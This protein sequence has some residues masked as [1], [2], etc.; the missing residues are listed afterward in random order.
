M[1]KVDSFYKRLQFQSI[2]DALTEL[3]AEDKGKYF[4]CNCPECNTHEAFIYKNNLKMIQCNRENH[5]GERMLLQFQD[6]KKKLPEQLNVQTEYPELNDE[7]QEALMWTTRL[8]SFA[9]NQTSSPTMDDGYRGLSKDVA[10]EHIIDLKHEDAVKAFFSKT[11][12]LLDKDYTHSKW[13]TKRNLFM[14]IYDEHNNVERLSMRSSIDETLEPKEI[15]LILNPSKNTKDYYSDISNKTNRLVISESL[16]DALSFKEIDRDTDFIALTGAKKTRK[17]EN[18]LRENKKDIKDKTIIIAMDNDDAGERASE[19]IQETLREIGK[20]EKVYSFHYAHGCKD[21]NELL[22]EDH[23]IFKK[24][25]QT[26]LFRKEH[27]KDMV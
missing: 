7:Q 22:Q 3:N 16:L 19:K 23:D 6:K 4:I 26:T 5:C 13:M 10:R 2:E 27:H 25:V 20:T 11:K 15:Q 18:F 12:V 24:D 9:K 17:A 8:F 21:A 14:P 1:M